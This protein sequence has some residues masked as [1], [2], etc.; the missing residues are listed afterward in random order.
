M[1]P[2]QREA[3]GGD[4]LRGG[5]SAEDSSSQGPFS[6]AITGRLCIAG[7]ARVA[8]EAAGVTACGEEWEV[9]DLLVHPLMSSLCDGTSESGL[10]RSPCV[11]APQSRS[12]WDAGL[13]GKIGS[14]SGLRRVQHS[15]RMPGHFF[16]S[17][18]GSPFSRSVSPPVLALCPAIDIDRCGADNTYLHANG[19]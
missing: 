12:R 6:Y 5:S 4:S 16:H 17:A 8:A 9:A 19:I 14:S 18:A 11:F 3:G 10:D 15:R 7:A 2:I 1:S 13:G